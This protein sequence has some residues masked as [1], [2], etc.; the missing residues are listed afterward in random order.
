MAFLDRIQACNRYDLAQFRPFVVANQRVGWVRRDIAAAL[1]ALP[2]VFAVTEAAVTLQPHLITAQQRTQ[3]FHD[4]V[5]ALPNLPPLRGEMY[6]VV[7]CWGQ[8]PLM[9]MD[10]GLVVTFG[11]PSHGVHVNGL[12]PSPPASWTT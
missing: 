6:P 5:R 11:V 8:P 7:T 3:A 2:Q 10:R 9:L 12:V 4:A 1:C